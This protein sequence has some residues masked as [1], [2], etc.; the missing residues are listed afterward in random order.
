MNFDPAYVPYPST[1]YPI[2]AREGIVATSSAQASAAGLEVLRQGGNAID[3]AVAAAATL[4]VTEPFSNSIGSDA[5]A[6]VW[7]GGKLYGLNASGK[8]PLNIS[9]EK[10][11]RVAASQTGLKKIPHLGWEPTMVPGAPRAWARLSERFG[12]LPL[13]KTMEGAIRYAREGYP[14]APNLPA[15]FTAAAEAYKSFGGDKT[16]FDEWYKTYMPWK[17]TPRAG[18]ILVLKNHAETLE[19]IADT[20]S[21]AFYKGQLADRIVADSEALGGYFCK[22]DFSSYDTE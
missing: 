15:F 22:E 8:A 6:I 12:K 16:I 7:T 20:N 13:K 17:D 11:K 3:A 4:T 18:D 10:L 21:D 14:L 2:Y 5:F 1:R 9:I 19:A